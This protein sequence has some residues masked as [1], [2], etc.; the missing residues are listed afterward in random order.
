MSWLSLL[1]PAQ[2]SKSFDQPRLTSPP[3]SFLWVV[4][5]MIPAGSRD[6]ACLLPALFLSGVS[7]APVASLH[8]L[9]APWPY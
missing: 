7:L 5:W 3:P 9:L 1:L 8:S 4:T 6:Q 2:L